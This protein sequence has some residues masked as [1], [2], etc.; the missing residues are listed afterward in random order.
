MRDNGPGKGPGFRAET[1][2]KRQ[3]KKDSARHSARKPVKG[4][5]VSRL[6]RYV[7]LEMPAWILVGVSIGYAILVSGGG[8][9]APV[10]QLLLL[11][12]AVAWLV[13]GRT[14]NPGWA[15]LLFGWA[16]GTMLLFNLFALDFGGV[17]FGLALLPVTVYLGVM[18][19]LLQMTSTARQRLTAAGG[20]LLAL[21]LQVVAL[22]V[23]VRT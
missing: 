9:L 2:R 14:T 1:A 17:P 10:F 11:V 12:G 21:A 3:S 16:L 8:G 18:V 22:V 6:R 20:A 5:E 7:L 4:G 15:S 13:A 19:V 23:L